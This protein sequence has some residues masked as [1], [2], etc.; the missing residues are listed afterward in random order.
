MSI[1][2]AAKPR[3]TANGR[4]L[5][6]VQTQPAPVA[7]FA[8]LSFAKRAPAEDADRIPLFEIDGVEYT[9]PA[10]IAAGDALMHLAM[11]GRFQNEA[12]RGMY[13]VGQLAGNDALAALLAE[14][15]MDV[16]DWQKLIKIL[17]EHTFGQLEAPGN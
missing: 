14:A 16:G 5:A 17:S 2:V 15:E 10:V 12:Q 13:L 8:A 7:P 4:A 11:V 3:K 9:I 1:Q 6:K